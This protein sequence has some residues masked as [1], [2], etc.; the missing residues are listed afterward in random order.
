MGPEKS[1]YES[2][3]TAMELHNKF[4]DELERAQAGKRLEKGAKAPVGEG[5][6]K[7]E[8]SVLPQGF[9]DN[10][11][12][13][14]LLDD[15]FMYYWSNG[16][17]CCVAV[18]PFADNFSDKAALKAGERWEDFIKNQDFLR[19]F[20]VNSQGLSQR[21]ESDIPAYWH[22]LL[23]DI[24]RRDVSQGGCTFQIQYPEPRLRNHESN[25]EWLKAQIR[26]ALENLR[27][28]F[29][30]DFGMPGEGGIH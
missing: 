27:A 3:E 29:G 9:L 18:L 8:C 14:A 4:V 10:V 19:L 7:D 13:D 16:L 24:L 28:F 12:V 6:Y 17:K 23:P 11:N 25:R 26:A 22:D 5:E 1:H 21:F 30:R 15:D 20:L 2:M